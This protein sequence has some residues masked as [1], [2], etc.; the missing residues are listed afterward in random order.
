[1]L[2]RLK[3]FDG[4]R[5]VL[6]SLT[7]FGIKFVEDRGWYKVDDDVADYLKT[8]KQRDTDPDSNAAFDVCTESQARAIDASEKTKAIRKAAE[9]AEPAKAP[10]RVHNVKRA[11]AATAARAAVA[12]VDEAGD[13]TTADLASHAKPA[14]PEEPADAAPGLSGDFDE[15]MAA[16][17]PKAP[18]ETGPAAGKGK[19]KGLG[20][21]PPLLE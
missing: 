18:G 16:T 4:K 1:M 7:V 13:L 6:R 11:E 8:V 2:A 15:D 21:K 14:A 9:E 5:H 19:S 10:M 20:R 3:P 17:T 12:N